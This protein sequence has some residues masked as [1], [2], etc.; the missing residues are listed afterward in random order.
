MRV[1]ITGGTGLIGRA[2]AASL[3]ADK[4]EVIVLS[5]SPQYARSMPGG[6]KV[7]K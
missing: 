3:A 5:R 6:V 7:E 1:V 4:H 2:Q